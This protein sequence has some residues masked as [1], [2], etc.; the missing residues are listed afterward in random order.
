MKRSYVVGGFLVVLLVVG[1]ALKGQKSENEAALKDATTEAIRVAVADANRALR[2]EQQTTVVRQVRA[3]CRGNL[4]RGY[5]LL[6]AREFV[7]TDQ[8][9]ASRTTKLAPKLF[10]ILNC[11][12]ALPL[13]EEEQRTYL[14]LLK[15]G[16]MP[17]LLDGEVVGY[18]GFPEPAPSN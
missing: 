8:A 11:E 6:R 4:L 16:L 15:R 12:T 17:T 18:T 3:T 5:L 9:G 7:M 13:A 14:G 2:E 1:L 10:P